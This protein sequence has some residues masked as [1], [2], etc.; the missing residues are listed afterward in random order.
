M[1]AP[2]SNNNRDILKRLEKELEDKNFA[3]PTLPDSAKKISDA[4]ADPNVSA[5]R[6]ARVIG[7]DAVLSGRL[8]QVANSPIF[9]G[10][11][12]I[13]D[14]QHA[15]SRLGLVCVRNLVISLTVNNL[16]KGKG[17]ETIQKKL[18]EVWQNGVKVAAVS[19]VLARGRWRIDPSE[20]L[21]AGLL[22][23]IGSIPI[24]NKLAE[25]KFKDVNEAT[26]N[27]ALLELEPNLSKWIME[28]WHLKPELAC[29]PVLIKDVKKDH[30]GPAN[31]AD[32]VQVARLH[33]YR[34][35]SH[36]LAKMKWVNIPSFSK[37]ELTPEDSVEIIKQARNEIKA[38]MGIL[39]GK[40]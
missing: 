18:K 26:I 8:I 2:E 39:Q 4:I 30:A 23:N 11:K 33:A 1:A 19:E 36:P 12:R 7:T 16:Y 14:L 29:V 17:N 21:L 15:I 32:I 10:L 40:S 35:S 28:H 6:V 13:E 9:Q 34:N 22:H 27:E 31:Y 3:L 25:P 38:V 20:A 5:T 24:L 37:L